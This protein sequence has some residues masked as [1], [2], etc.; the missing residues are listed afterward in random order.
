MDLR[1]VG[2]PDSGERSRRN[3]P[4]SHG[5]RRE[6]IDALQLP[7]WMDR[8]TAIDEDT[9]DMEKSTVNVTR[10]TP[11]ARRALRVALPSLGRGWK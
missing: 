9:A 3:H 1:C 2:L 10:D 11:S 7:H 6:L 5:N 8:L 4:H